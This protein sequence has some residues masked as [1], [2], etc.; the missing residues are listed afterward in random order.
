[1]GAIDDI[2]V[3]NQRRMSESSGS[4]TYTGTRL[5]YTRTGFGN[6][7]SKSTGITVGDVTFIH[8]GKAVASVTQIKDPHGLARLA[9]SARKQYALLEKAM[10]KN[11]TANKKKE[12]T[13]VVCS[14]CGAS[15]A[16]G[17]NFCNS[18]GNTVR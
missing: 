13:S 16:T 12:E 17:S 15:N 11:L 10:K 14:K 9:K 7:R 6:T 3:T 18:C 8:Q 4:G 1:M 2:V 5:G